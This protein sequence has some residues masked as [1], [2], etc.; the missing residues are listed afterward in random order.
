MPQVWDTQY[1]RLNR[2]RSDAIV[3]GEW[4]GRMVGS[5]ATWQVSVITVNVPFV[6]LS[7]PPLHS[8][9]R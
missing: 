9:L 4:G 6:F 1:G 3:I 8:P 2:A 5:D 7:H